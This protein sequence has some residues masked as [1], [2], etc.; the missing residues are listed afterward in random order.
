MKGSNFVTLTVGHTYLNRKGEIRVIVRH[1]SRAIDYKFEDSEERI[2][3]LDGHFFFDGR[4]DD[5]DLVVDITVSG[6]V[7]PVKESISDPDQRS[8]RDNIARRA[9]EARRTDFAIAAMQ[10]K[11]ANGTY[12]SIAHDAWAVSDLM[13]AEWQ[14]RFGR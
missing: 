5:R 1:N 8:V 4:Q 13:E 10:G 2:Y 6:D 7:T 3:T 9:D 11:L 12:S 14:R